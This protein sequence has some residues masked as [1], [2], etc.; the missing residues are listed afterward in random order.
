MVIGAAALLGRCT[1]PPEGHPAECAVSGGA[2]SLAL[3]ILAVTAGC[4][5]TAIHVDHGLRPGS[6]CEADLVAGA[7]A[8]LGA[9]FRS[10]R[11]HIE[12]GPNLE[13]RARDARYSVLPPGVLTGHTADDQAETMILNLLRG[14]GSNGMAAMAA[15]QHPILDLRRSETEGLCAEAGFKP[16]DDPSNCDSIHRRNR[17]RHEVVPLLAEVADRDIVPILVRQAR[18]FADDARLLDSLAEAIDATDARVLAAAPPA[19][20]RRAVR[21]WLRQD[22]PYPPDFATV[23]RVLAVARHQ[24]RSTDVGAGRRVTRHSGRLELR[25][26]LPSGANGIPA[27]P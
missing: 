7:A 9:E 3:L 4:L 17:V 11:V 24:V 19:L 5:T 21:R 23:E 16:L 6:E 13:A 1:F 22:Q 27:A 14:A 20:A 10:Q 12:P 2:D 8:L 26:P 25:G 15:P 18:L